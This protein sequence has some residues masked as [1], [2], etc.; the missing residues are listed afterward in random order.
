MWILPCYQ[1]Q[2][3]RMKDLTNGYLYT[4]DCNKSEFNV[5]GRSGTALLRVERLVSGIGEVLWTKCYQFSTGN[6]IQKIFVCW[7][8]YS[9]QWCVDPKVHRR[10]NKGVT[11]GSHVN[12]YG[13][14]GADILH[15]P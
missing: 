6:R 7:G 9:L 13:M 10:S 1:K 4:G 14:A 8:V 12:T 15:L 2:S 11:K 3:L 5:S